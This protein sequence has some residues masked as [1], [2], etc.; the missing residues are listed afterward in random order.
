MAHLLLGDLERLEVVADNPEL[1]L[2][3]DNLGL[4]GLGALL[5][6]LEVGLNHGQLSGNLRHK[7]LC[8]RGSKCARRIY[9]VSKNLTLRILS[10]KKRL[11]NRLKLKNY[12]F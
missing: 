2:E 6:P 8:K 4:A 3:L 10:V 7:V 11:K 1:L 9:R 12:L 5:S